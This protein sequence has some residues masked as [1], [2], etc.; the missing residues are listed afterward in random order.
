LVVM[1]V[2]AGWCFLGLEALISDVGGV[3]GHSGKPFLLITCE[4]SLSTENHHP[5]PRYASE[6]L[7]ESLD[8][9]PSF[10]RYYRSRLVVSRGEEDP[11]VLELD[12]RNRK[13]WGE[14]W[15]PSFA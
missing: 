14:E 3:F 4:K 7:H 9:S 2:I 1:S 13:G 10:M 5:L 6:I 12:R 11:S 8:L 15:M